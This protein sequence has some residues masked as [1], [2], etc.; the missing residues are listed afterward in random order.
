MKFPRTAVAGSAPAAVSGAGPGLAYDGR[1]RRGVALCRTVDILLSPPEPAPGG[2]PVTGPAGETFGK[3][4][5]PAPYGA[6]AECAAVPRR[7]A[8][9]LITLG[10]AAPTD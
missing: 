10:G 8:R 2:R 4:C 6:G 7:L 9:K 5:T 3:Q 1:R